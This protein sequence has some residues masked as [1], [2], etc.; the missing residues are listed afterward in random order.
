MEK[1]KKIIISAVVLII[2]VGIII[3][4]LNSG[5]PKSVTTTT[6]SIESHQPITDEEKLQIEVWIQKNNLNQYGDSIDTMYMG[7]TPLFNE[8]TGETV[9]VYDYIL[10]NHLDKPWKE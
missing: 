5:E 7:G 10:E 6:T 8:M 9:S 2:T 3:F 1:N 4:L